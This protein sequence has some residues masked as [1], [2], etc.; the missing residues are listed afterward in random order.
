MCDDSNQTMT[1]TKDYLNIKD[2]STKTLNDSLFALKFHTETNSDVFEVN[3]NKMKYV[4]PYN[5]CPC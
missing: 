5:F 4:L 1:N 3:N 2:C